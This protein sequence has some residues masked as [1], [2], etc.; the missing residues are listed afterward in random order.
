[1]SVSPVKD[2]ISFTVLPSSFACL[3]LSLSSGLRGEYKEVR[4]QCLKGCVTSGTNQTGWP[5]GTWSVNTVSEDF[6]G[7]PHSL[8]DD[9]NDMLNTLITP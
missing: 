7:F 8:Q 3:S 4:L 2:I 5:S 9:T 1:M 6:H